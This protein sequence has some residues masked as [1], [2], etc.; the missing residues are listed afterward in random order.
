[1]IALWMIYLVAITA[2]LGFGAALLE[3]V[4]AA[5]AWPRRW[6]WL[7]G[8]STVPIIVSASVMRSTRVDPVA[9]AARTV[10][11]KEPSRD[12]RFDWGAG[13]ARFTRNR[14]NLERA[15]APMQVVWG[16]GVA[17]VVLHYLACVALLVRQRRRWRRSLVDGTT[18][19]VS[20][21]LGPAVVG[22]LRP[23][24][25]LPEWALE[26]APNELALIL[27]HE[28]EHARARDPLVLQLAWFGVLAMPWNPAAWWMLKRLRVAVE[29]DCDA[30]VLRVTTDRTAYGA[31]LLS[32]GL[33]HRGRVPAMA[34]ALLERTSTL[35][36]RILAMQDHRRRFPRL[37]A[38]AATAGAVGA[39]AVACAAPSPEALA[40]DGRESTQR[41]AG[42]VELAPV[43][44]DSLRAIVL[45]N[46]PELAAGKMDST[47][48][49]LV[50]DSNGQV[51]MN[52][53]VLSHN[54]ADKM[55]RVRLGQEIEKG[56]SIGLASAKIDNPLES[57]DPA[58]VAAV[59][60]L[61]KAAGTVAPSPVS[62]VRV[63]LKPT[64][65]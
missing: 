33:R 11:M 59:D 35:T 22:V 52:K 38:I 29:L 19:L 53:A 27:A 28:R 46:F 5:R 13:L 26:A 56:P 64:P 25:V 3:R 60:V 34:P 39:L 49:F 18:V 63:R 10:R 51:V 65:K 41:L 62:F 50:E 32:V 31:L 23:E 42:K 16:T 43:S 61:K 36:R 30:R 7:L 40:P 48:V 2:L 21:N 6:V 20:P 44:N 45:K 55:R 12:A 1:M 15:A 57:I 54:L 4:A 8:L 58:Q 37:S 9:P 24:V 17:L 47:V 14:A